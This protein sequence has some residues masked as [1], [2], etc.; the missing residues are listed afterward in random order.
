MTTTLATSARNAAADA[1]VD[2]FDAGAGAGTVEIRSGTKPANPNTAPSDGALLATLTLSDPAFGSAVNGTA[3]ANA[4]TSDSSADATGTASWFR[5]Q[6]S[7]GNAVLD[8]SVGTS[9][10]DMNL[11]TTSIVAG[12]IVAITSWTYTQPV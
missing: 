12:A 5:G 6:D 3:T 9:G 7:N 8:G 1:V 11:N 10:Q 2:L 4:I